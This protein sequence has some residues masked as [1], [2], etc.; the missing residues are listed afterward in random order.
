[1]DLELRGRAVLVT[2]GSKGL[3]YETARAFLAEGARVTICGRGRESLDRAVRSLG[4]LGEVR[5]VQADVAKESE[6]ADLIADVKDAYGELDVLVNNAGRIRP[7]AFM[8]FSDEVWKEELNGKLLGAIRV[9]RHA[10]PIMTRKGWGAVINLSGL[11]GK[12]LFP[13]GV[14]TGVI[15]AGVIAFTKYLAEY[16]APLGIRANSICP[17]VAR[18]EAWEERGTTIAANQ[19]IDKEAF[20]ANFVRANNI[21]LGRWARPAEIADA[22]VLLASSRMS[23]VTGHTLMVD[24]GFFKYIG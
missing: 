13:N 3:G 24:G 20:F 8:E 5:A 9:T 21:L 12:Q 11:T 23:Y 15:N 18:T 1:M 16:A 22:V 17:G 14:I 7:G 10:I 6:V 2:G 4:E 19:G